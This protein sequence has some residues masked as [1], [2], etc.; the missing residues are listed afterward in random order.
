MIKGTCKWYYQSSRLVQ[1]VTLL[2]LTY[3]LVSEL[4]RLSVQ[5]PGGATLQVTQSPFFATSERLDRFFWTCDGQSL[6]FVSVQWVVF[7]R[8]FGL[9][10]MFVMPA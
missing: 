9:K 7:D 8:Y 6:F 4:D 5:S 2:L 3:P 1:L 10:N